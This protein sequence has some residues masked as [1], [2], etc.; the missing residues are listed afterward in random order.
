MKFKKNPAVLVLILIICSLFMPLSINYT[1]QS[2]IFNSNKLSRYV[3]LSRLEQVSTSNLTYY[4][5]SKAGFKIKYELG[6]YEGVSNGVV[7]CGNYFRNIFVGTLLDYLDGFR[8]K[9]SEMKIVWLFFGIF[10]EG[11]KNILFSSLELIAIVL[12]LLL[13]ST[14]SYTYILSYMFT[15]LFI[16][17]IAYVFKKQ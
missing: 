15:L 11:L 9:S 7:V 6:L 8:L 5:K 14:V 4:A 2:K 1:G 10:L 3:S 12:I 17:G 13:Q 16:V